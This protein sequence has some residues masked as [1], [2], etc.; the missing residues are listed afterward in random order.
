MKR[1]LTVMLAGSMLMSAAA[2]AGE[3]TFLAGVKPDYKAEPALSVIAGQMSPG[4]SGMKDGTIT[5]IELSL[6]CPLLQPPTNRIRQQVSLT[7][8]DESGTKITNIEL[9]PHYVVE[10]L[11]GLELGGGPGLGYIMTDTPAL[12]PNLWGLSVGL[13]AHYTAMGPLFLGAEYRYQVTSKKNFG[14]SIGK[15]NLNNGRFDIKVGY[16]F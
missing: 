15:D 3:W 14:G 1:S 6:N 2:H 12:D 13:S 7:Q 8:Y 16:S 11:P 10:V 5:G 4:I 9:N